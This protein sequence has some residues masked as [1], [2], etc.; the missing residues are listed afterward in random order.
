MQTPG[1]EIRTATTFVDADSS[2]GQKPQ[3][4]SDFGMS[5]LSTMAMGIAVAC[6]DVQRIHFGKSGEDFDFW[7]VPI[8]GGRWGYPR[9]DGLNIPWKW[10]VRGYPPF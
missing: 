7:G 1:V 2:A 6:A 8:D 5:T 9:M 3:E 4:S 10:I